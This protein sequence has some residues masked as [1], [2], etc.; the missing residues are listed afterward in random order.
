MFILNEERLRRLY[1]LNHFP[2]PDDEMLFFGLRGCLPAHLADQAFRSEHELVVV[3]IDHIHPRCTIGQWQPGQGIA[4]FPGS[5]VPHRR[6]IEEALAHNG[7]GTNQLMTGFFYNFRKDV[8]KRGEPTGHEAFRY[9]QE[10]PIRRT[11]DNLTYDEYDRVEYMIPYDNLHAGWSQG[12][13]HDRFG[14]AGC[15][16]VVGY[17]QCED[18]G[19]EPDSGPWKIFK[20]N[21]YALAQESFSYL[22]LEGRYVQKAVAATADE[23]M[24]RL[25]Y[26]SQGAL[27]AALQTRLKEQGCYEGEVDGH[28]GAKTLFAVLSFQTSRLGQGLS[29]GIVGPMTAHALGMDWPI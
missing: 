9:T 6:H 18:R 7:N 16:V 14:S 8:H 1:Q 15:Q 28:F 2:I 22:L 13:E 23:P 12:V 21:A 3:E 20:A 11:A 17:P 19:N 26:G 10:L 25:R 5:T 27:V 29:D 4:L 24:A